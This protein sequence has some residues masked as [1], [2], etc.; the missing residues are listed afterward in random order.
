MQNEAQQHK[1]YYHSIPND[2]FRQ[3]ADIEVGKY[4]GEHLRYDREV[5]G[6][7][8]YPAK[9]YEM[10]GDEHAGEIQH[11]FVLETPSG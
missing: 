3:H 5:G 10:E 1:K 8:K 7:E 9:A 6:A 4:L 2:K 11:G